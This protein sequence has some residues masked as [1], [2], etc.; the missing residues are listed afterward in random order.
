MKYKIKYDKNRDRYEVLQ[1][2]LPI[3]TLTGENLLELGQKIITTFINK[4]YQI[5]NP[6]KLGN[7]Q[8]FSKYHYIKGF[9]K[10]W[11]I[12]AKRTIKK[13]ASRKTT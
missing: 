8:G 12:D 5:I 9:A 3:L 10:G 7:A 6:K 11:L 1:E 4:D 13:Y 2:G